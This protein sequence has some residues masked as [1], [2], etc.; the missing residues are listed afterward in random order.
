MMKIHQ[1]N[2]T[3]EEVF[4][5]QEKQVIFMPFRQANELQDKV[6]YRKEDNEHNTEEILVP[7]EQENTPDITTDTN[8]SD[9]PPVAD[10]VI[11]DGTSGVS[12]SSTVKPEEH[13]QE[14]QQV[15]IPVQFSSKTKAPTKRYNLRSRPV[16]KN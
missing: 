3:D 4:K 14:K 12:T 10:E 13:V 1:K 2:S 8:E 16:P 11:L 9:V 15:E 7:N 6:L 5:E